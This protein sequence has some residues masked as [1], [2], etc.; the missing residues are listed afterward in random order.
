MSSI[1]VF[2]S[3]SREDKSL[4]EAWVNEIAAHGLVV[5]WDNDLPPGATWDAYIPDRI[6]EARSVLVLW[7]NA[8]VTSDYVKDEA[9]IAREKGKL[10]PVSIDGVAAPFGFGS[11][12]TL[13]ASAREAESGA[14][15]FLAAYGA[16]TGQNKQPETV[17]IPKNSRWADLANRLKEYGPAVVRAALLEDDGE[18][19]R[20]LAQKASLTNMLKEFWSSQST[21]RKVVAAT[22]VGT[23]FGILML[24]PLG[25]IVWPLLALGGALGF[26]KASAAFAKPMQKKLLEAAVEKGSL[27]ARTELLNL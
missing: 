26:H 6:A 16:M 13:G 22:G 19:L 7:T 25:P 17:E 9:R 23:Y 20:L 24:G 12:Q 3:Y 15:A 21:D 18:A 8:S 11:I 2:V 14:K 5:W 27:R 4:A 1:D 10:I